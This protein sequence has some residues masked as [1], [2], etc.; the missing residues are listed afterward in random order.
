MWEIAHETSAA[1]PGLLVID[2]PQKNLGHNSGAND[3]DFADATLVENFYM[4]AKSWLAT[5]G[6]GAQLIVIDNSPPDAVTDDVVVRYTR[7]A[8]IEPY[9]LITDATS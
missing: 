8:K 5:E 9:G 6:T 7:N 1:A 2:S 4:H 3:T